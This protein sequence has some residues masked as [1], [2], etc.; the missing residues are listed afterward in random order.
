MSAA[1]LLYR[2]R[3]KALPRYF[4]AGDSRKRWQ[5]GSFIFLGVVVF[6]VVLAASAAFFRALLAGETGGE[7]LATG[8]LSATFNLTVVILLITGFAAA[9]YTFYLSE[10]LA[11]LSASPIRQRTIFTYKFAD[12]LLTNTPLFVCLGLPITIAYVIFASEGPL[13]LAL[14]TPVLVAVWALSL[15]LPTALCILF[16]MPL[17]RVLPASRAKEIVAGVGAL[18]GAAAYLVYLRLIGPGDTGGS[19]SASQGAISTLRPLLESPV[20]NAPPGSWAADALSGAASL[21]WVMLASGLAL[22]SA[23]AVAAYLLCL[24]VSS[25]AYATGVARASESGSRSGS[26]TLAGPLSARLLAPLP[27]RVRIVVFKELRSLRR[28]FRRLSS[29]AA[30]L[31]I[32]MGVFFINSGG[33]FGAGDGPWFLLLLAYLPAFG[34]GALLSALLAAYSVGSE[35][36]A[37]WYLHASPLKAWEIMAGKLAASVLCGVLASVAGAA[38]VAVISGAPSVAGIAFA[39]AGGAVAAVVCG[40][41]GIGVS[42]LY[43]SFEGDNPNQALTQM[44]NFVMALLFFALFAAVGL[45]VGIA[46]ALASF[47]P[48]WVAVLAAAAAWTAGCGIGGYAVASS[49]AVSLERV[50]Q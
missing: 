19:A 31:V 42:A 35:G 2:L 12:T 21:E 25:W 40:L 23:L 48:V 14:Y 46:F 38:I 11:I 7:A 26:S 4:T 49:G 18:L 13:S 33:S 6:F 39:V 10:D 9:L 24:T 47:L 45:A 1:A 17:M 15:A 20:L 27:R 8:A 44:G 41:Y 36:P 37:Y 43:A 16:S 22:L 29:V 34:A 50:D 3:I 28:D 32:L 30:P 5:Y